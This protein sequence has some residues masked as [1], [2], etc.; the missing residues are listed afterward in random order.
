MGVRKKEGVIDEG[1]AA[2]VKI[3]VELPQEAVNRSAFTCSYITSRHIQNG[4][5]ILLQINFLNPV[6]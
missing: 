6:H 4:L 2:T 5:Y 3:I 1:R